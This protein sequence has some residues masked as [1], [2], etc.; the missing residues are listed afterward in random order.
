VETSVA[1][2]RKANRSGFRVAEKA[3]ALPGAEVVIG[4]TGTCS[5]TLDD[6]R[7]LPSGAVVAS[8]SSKQVEIDME[9]LARAS[10][11]RAPV[12]ASS[13]LVRLPTVRYQLGRA[14]LTVLGDGWPVNF[15]GD[16]EDIPAGLIQLTRAV[17][18]A[19]AL[20]AAG[21]KTNYTKNRGMMPLDSKVDRQILR[22]FRA[23]DQHPSWQAHD[24]GRWPEVVREVATALR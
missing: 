17:M 18:F 5:L 22:R 14:Q 23:L 10:R 12:A 9:G 15:D 16:V 2:A 20:Q 13:P 19:G 6:L 1:R 4:A 24:P 21:I 7:L 8:A 3:Q 11:S